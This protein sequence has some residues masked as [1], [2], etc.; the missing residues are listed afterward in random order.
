MVVRVPEPGPVDHA[1]LQVQVNAL[2]QKFALQSG[3]VASMY[4]FFY[5]DANR[6][7]RT[8]W[9]PSLAPHGVATEYR[10]VT[11]DPSIAI[12]GQDEHVP[13]VMWRGNEINY[14]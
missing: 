10:A 1:T 12:V 6:G 9:I 13:S 5:N 7:G 4:T 8:A 14:P 3:V 11:G 2:A